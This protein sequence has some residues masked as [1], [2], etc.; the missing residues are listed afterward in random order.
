MQSSAG[1]ETWSG[2]SWSLLADE[3][4][5]PEGVLEM[6]QEAGRCAAVPILTA[7]CQAKMDWALRSCPPVEAY[8]IGP[9]SNVDDICQDKKRQEG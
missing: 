5:V 6:F 7:Q 3:S 8:L 1:G 4:C 9:L 2:I